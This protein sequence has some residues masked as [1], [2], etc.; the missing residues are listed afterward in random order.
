MKSD[1]II[2]QEG[3]K[4]LKEKLGDIDT[5]RFIVLVNREKFDYTRWRK[6]LFE[7]LSIDDLADRADKFSR[8]L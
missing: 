5:E 1:T 6:E 3:F 8:S 4:A 2:K 7:D